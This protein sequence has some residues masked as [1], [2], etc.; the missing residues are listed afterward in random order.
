[1]G[2]TS[3]GQAQKARHCFYHSLSSLDRQ[4]RT[5]GLY[6]EI[7]KLIKLNAKQILVIS[8]CRQVPAW[9]C[10]SVRKRPAPWKDRS[11]Y[12][13]ITTN[14]SQACC[15]PQIYTSHD[16][17]VCIAHLLPESIFEELPLS[18][19]WLDSWA[20]T[21]QWTILG[22]SIRVVKPVLSRS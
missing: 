11:A 9:I 4:Q 3:L 15:I 13:Y 12:V 17:S 20:D 2:M 10:S 16:D 22:F 18:P 8:I 19:L 6:F 14:L 7:I 21:N 1:M 5:T